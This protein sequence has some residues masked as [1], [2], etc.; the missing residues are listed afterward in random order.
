MVGPEGK[1]KEFVIYAEQAKHCGLLRAARERNSNVPQLS[2]RWPN[3][4]VEDFEL[5][6]LFIYTGHI[7]TMKPGTMAPSGHILQSSGLSDT[8]SSRPASRTK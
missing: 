1:T 3:F 8:N 6:V 2:L 5:F 4:P 7:F